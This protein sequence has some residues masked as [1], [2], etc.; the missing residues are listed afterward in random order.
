MPSERVITISRRIESLSAYKSPAN[1]MASF[2]G[3]G[4][5]L[6]F[7]YIFIDSNYLNIPALYSFRVIELSRSDIMKLSISIWLLT[8]GTVAIGTDLFV[9]AGIL[10]YVANSFAVSAQTA[11]YLV[12]V[13]AIIY[14]VFGPILA[15]RTASWHKRKLL[16]MTLGIF[17]VGEA[18]SALAIN[19]YIMIV[20]RVI[21]AVGASLFTPTAF[22][23]AVTLVPEEKKG[24]AL[25]LVSGGL[26]LSMAITV[27]IGTW[28]SLLFG[29]RFTYLFIMVIGIIAAV[30]LA[31]VLE[32]PSKNNIPSIFNSS[33]APSSTF[34]SSFVLAVVAYTFWGMGIFSIFPF[35]SLILT[36]NLHVHPVDVGYALMLFGTGSFIGVILGGHATDR[37]GHMKTTKISISISVIALISSYL[38]LY[39]SSF[40][41]ILS[42][43]VFSMAIQGFMPSQLRRVVYFSPKNSHQTALAINNSMLYIGIAL[44][45]VLG[46]S[47]F[48]YFS[49]SILPLVSGISVIIALGLSL[50]SWKLEKVRL[51]SANQNANLVN[52]T[53]FPH[54]MDRPEP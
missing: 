27:P 2:S 11:G 22:A 8:L 30:G 26:I 45:T 17:I 29:W 37:W 14:A 40:W 35:I 34:R 3:Y 1:V 33:N 52:E 38:L 28:V 44:G 39:K 50:T 15:R 4:K 7:M 36:G 42:Y 46:G 23:V 9:I 41:F 20:A 12:T 31:L 25:S 21:S 51:I 5:Y 16:V 47:L 43:F 10:P 32:T 19:F 13:F 54:E 49:L 53:S 48:G 6:M 24:R 18:I